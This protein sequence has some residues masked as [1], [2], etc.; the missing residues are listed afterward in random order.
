MKVAFSDFSPRIREAR[1]EECQMRQYTSKPKPCLNQVSFNTCFRARFPVQL[2]PF[3]PRRPAFQRRKAISGPLCPLRGVSFRIKKGLAFRA[4]MPPSS[5][6]AKLDPLY[7]ALLHF[8]QHRYEASAAACTAMLEKNPY[9]EA[10]W[11]LKT[12]ALTAQVRELRLVHAGKSEPIAELTST[13]DG[14]RHRGGRG[15]H[16]GR[17]PGRQRHQVGQNHNA[18]NLSYL[19]R[20]RNV[21]SPGRCPGRGPRSGAQ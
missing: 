12:R 10:V 18:E 6:S 17:G 11:S 5:V 20:G 19:I 2:A 8:R 3:F 15:R 21:C 4:K 14:G 16:R 1:D 13:G 7:V 9:D